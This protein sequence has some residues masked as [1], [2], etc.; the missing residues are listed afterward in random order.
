MPV[1]NEILTNRLDKKINYGVARTAYDSVKSPV[2]EAIGSPS[3]NPAS[4][5][6]ILSSM[7]NF[8]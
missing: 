7:F 1:S 8:K 5:W 6:K 3:P 2:Q 4:I